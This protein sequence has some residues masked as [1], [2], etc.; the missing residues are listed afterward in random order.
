MKHYIEL[1][2]TDN[3]GL[4]P[5]ANLLL[6]LAIIPVDGEIVDVLLRRE[7]A[8][9]IGGDIHFDIQ[10]GANSSSL[11]SIFTTDARRPILVFAALSGGT[12]HPGDFPIACNAQ[13]S[14][15]FYR[16]DSTS[17][18]GDQRY[19][20]I[21]VIEDGNSGAEIENA[22]TITTSSLVN[23]ADTTGTVS[24]AKVATLLEITVDRNARIRFYQTA[25][26]RTADA[27]RVFGAGP[28]P[29]GLIFDVLL[30]GTTGLD[31]SFTP[32]VICV[33]GDS[34]R[35]SDIYWTIQNLSGATHTVSVD[36]E[37]AV[38]VS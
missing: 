10:T 9:P 5:R 4:N 13:D 26:A 33:N 23:N 2:N 20:A 6:A 34:P 16:K 24:L 27:A 21:V 8:S 31:Y 35:V 3:A 37:S 38:M 15:G 18:G 32:P 11:S 1:I 7:A 28:Y 12:S 29:E 19:T 22:P 36:I 25:A 30:D 17:A 14:I